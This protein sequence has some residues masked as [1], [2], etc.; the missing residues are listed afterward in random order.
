MNSQAHNEQATTTEELIVQYLDGE[1]MRKELEGVLF[2]RLARS[3]E[4]R[5][6][7]RE[8]LMLRGAIRATLDHE[9]FQLSSDLDDRTRLRIEE[10]LKQGADVPG[11]LAMEPN[12]APIATNPATRSLKR[13]SMRPAYAALLLLLAVGTTWFVTRTSDIRS[14]N[15]QLAQ[16]GSKGQDVLPPSTLAP[17]VTSAPSNHGASSVDAAQANGSNDVAVA[18]AIAKNVEPRTR[19]REVIKYVPA[20]A[21]SQSSNRE[22]AQMNQQPAKPAQ[23]AADPADI[24]ISHRYAKLLNATSKR[25]VV[26]S[27]KDRL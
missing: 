24:M 22:M 16:N 9:S 25:E 27:G 8:H 12:A 20:P 5:M 1:L 7:L 10:M 15:N 14:G 21:P 11:V 13:W 2:E 19:V 17:P 4:A 3:E 23:D 6:L 26:I 18:P